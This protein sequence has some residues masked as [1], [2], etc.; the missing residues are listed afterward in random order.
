L[1]DETKALARLIRTTLLSFAGL[2]AAFSQPAFRLEVLVLLF[3]V[4]AALLL[5]DDAVQR[6]LL[7][8]SW[9]LAIVVEILN[10]AVETVVDRIGKDYHELSERAKD[11]GLAAVLLFHL[12]GIWRL[13][14][15]FSQRPVTLRIARRPS[16]CRI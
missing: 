4:P 11:L 7:I 3:A 8:A 10:S 9:M 13:D 14:P 15:R 12:A 16:R 1:H 6:A 2:R 5:T